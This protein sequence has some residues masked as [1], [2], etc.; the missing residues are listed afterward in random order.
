ME[1]K[2]SNS[3]KT[4]MFQYVFQGKKLNKAK[5]NDQ[6]WM[7]YS[8]TETVIPKGAYKE[9]R[10]GIQLTLRE[11]YQGL[12]LSNQNMAR[13]HGVTV[14]ASPTNF[15]GDEIKF[16]LINHGPEDYRVLRGQAV[17]LLQLIKAA[18]N[19][20]LRAIPIEEYQD[21]QEEAEKAWS[22]AQDKKVNE[23]SHK[24]DIRN[25]YTSEEEFHRLN[26]EYKEEMERKKKE[27]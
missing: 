3:E 23:E 16:P 9:V 24:E 8:E 13:N 26:K 11:G 6:C 22:E 27:K 15:T 12:V 2:D 25:S 7:L 5:N 21:W 4:V 17:G 20:E 18:T 19:Y 10:T 1:I 14:L